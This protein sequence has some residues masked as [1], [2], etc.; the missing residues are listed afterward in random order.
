[1]ATL[2]GRLAAEAIAGRAQG[3]DILANLPPM[4]F[5]GGAQMR[6]P[7]LVAAMLWYGLRDRF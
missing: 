4:P 2:G 6:S 7:L 3:F 1:M 5:P